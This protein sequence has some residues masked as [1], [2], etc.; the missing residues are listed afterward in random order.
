MKQLLWT[1]AVVGAFALGCDDSGDPS[2]EGTGDSGPS[3][4][5]VPGD[6]GADGA[7]G[8]VPM[9]DGTVE[10]DMAQV[11]PDDGVEAD[12][13]EV[14]PDGAID[15]DM[16]VM[17][18]E[19]PEPDMAPP[20]P[21]AAPLADAGMECMDD[22]ACGANSV[23]QEGFCR[24]DLRPLVFRLDSGGGGACPG[25]DLCVNEPLAAAP[26]LTAALRIAVAQNAL[27]L[28]FE[29]GYYD[30]E[31]GYTFYVGNGSQ[32]GGSFDF[33]HTLPI[34]NFAGHWRTAEG[35][36]RWVMDGNNDFNVVVPGGTVDDG[37]GNMVT[38]LVNFVTTV[39]MEFWLEEDE[40]GGPILKGTAD[41]FLLDED[42]DAVVLQGISFREF[43]GDEV[44]DLD[45]DA[46]GE[47]DAWTFQFEATMR[48]VP[49]RGDPPD[50]E[51]RDPS[52]EIQY[53][54]PAP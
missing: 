15:P 53:P 25:A 48:P 45:L 43:F 16:S 39:H 6:T 34:Q 32:E 22:E 10:A 52:P 27:N 51:N 47:F 14:E 13:A 50:G 54:C 28:L 35:Q 31:G 5:A 30:D 12:M 20:E 8:N 18:D 19:G 41:G 11:D 3:D 24:Y 2:G 1:L 37:M 9:P 23:C 33:I 44:P 21:D 46:D 7:G 36:T 40:D 42:I 49:F 17:P 4:S 26:E 29:P 38:C